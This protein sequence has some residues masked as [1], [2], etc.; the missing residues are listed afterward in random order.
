MDKVNEVFVSFIPALYALYVVTADV[1]KVL[2][3]RLCI[4]DFKA[5]ACDVVVAAFAPASI[6]VIRDVVVCWRYSVYCVEVV[7]LLSFHFR[8]LFSCY[9]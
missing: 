4:V 9:R 1:F 8:S 3:V 5:G 6:D 7:G 2:A